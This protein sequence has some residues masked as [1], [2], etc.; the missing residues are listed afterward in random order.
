L[1]FVCRVV[2]LPF[3]AQLLG[4]EGAYQMKRPASLP[5]CPGSWS[6]RILTRGRRLRSLTAAT[7]A[8]TQDRARVAHNRVKMPDLC[9]IGAPEASDPP[10]LAQ[11]PRFKLAHPFIA[12]QGKDLRD[13]RDGSLYP[14]DAALTENL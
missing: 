2:G 9:K 8:R 13:S 10:A 7:R 1:A 12:L 6:N 11:K 14:C 3:G 4:F 5:A